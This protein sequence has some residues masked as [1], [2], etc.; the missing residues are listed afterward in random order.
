MAR[1]DIQLSILKTRSY[2]HVAEH[3][4][5]YCQGLTVF[6]RQDNNK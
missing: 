2:R 3:S 6:E 4:E 5:A 1:S